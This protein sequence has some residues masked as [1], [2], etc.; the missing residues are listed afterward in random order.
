MIA[1]LDLERDLRSFGKAHRL[2]RICTEEPGER[3]HEGVL[4]R[5]DRPR[6]IEQCALQIV[7]EIALDVVSPLTAATRVGSEAKLVIGL[8]DKPE[9]T[10]FLQRVAEERRRGLAILIGAAA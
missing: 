4:L 9:P 10:R 8:L 3:E 1:D 7:M 2:E 5:F 6:G